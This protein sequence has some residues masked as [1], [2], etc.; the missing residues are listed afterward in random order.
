MTTYGTSNT[1]NGTKDVQISNYI[2]FRRF[3]NKFNQKKT[4]LDIDFKALGMLSY[5]AC[6]NWMRYAINNGTFMTII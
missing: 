1:E 6:G 5:N 4:L 2:V 3:R